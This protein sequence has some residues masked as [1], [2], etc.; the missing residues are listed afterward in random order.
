MRQEEDVG[1][2]FVWACWEWGF[3]TVRSPPEACWRGNEK[4]GRGRGGAGRQRPICSNHSLAAHRSAR[5]SVSC[6]CASTIAHL[7]KKTKKR[8][9]FTVLSHHLCTFFFSYTF[10]VSPA[11]WGPGVPFFFTFLFLT[12]TMNHAP[13]INTQHMPV[14]TDTHSHVVIKPANFFKWSTCDSAKQVIAL[15]WV[16]G[17]HFSIPDC[18]IWRIFSMEAYQEQ[19]LYTTVQRTNTWCHQNTHRNGKLMSDKWECNQ[20]QEFPY[21]P[22]TCSN[23]AQTA[24][25]WEN[26]WRRWKSLAIYSLLFSTKCNT[27]ND[28]IYSYVK[29]GC[30]A[31]RSAEWLDSVLFI[32]WT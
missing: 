27:D 24:L 11:W 5:L 6:L 22:S 2:E 28:N 4:T 1:G 8:S 16:M 23:Q 14:C 30:L 15:M 29:N 3:H 32:W 9:L 7:K 19:L 20:L 17:S 12:P 31:S 18:L 21:F 25:L 10:W 13:L 26:G